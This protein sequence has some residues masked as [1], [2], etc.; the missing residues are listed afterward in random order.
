MPGSQAYHFSTYIAHE[1]DLPHVEESFLDSLSGP[2]IIGLAFIA[3]SLAILIVLLVS[4]L[5]SS[6][7]SQVEINNKGTSQN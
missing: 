2:A 4:R 1:S 6:Q 3:A 5:T 7:R